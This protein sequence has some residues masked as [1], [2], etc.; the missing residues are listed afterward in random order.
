MP[1]SQLVLVVIDETGHRRDF[2]DAAQRQLIVDP[3]SVG[4]LA[5]EREPQ[6]RFSE[7][8]VG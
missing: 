3:A 8:K 4:D 1:L 5:R 6:A 2:V 7:T